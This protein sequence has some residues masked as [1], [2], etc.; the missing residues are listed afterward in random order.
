MV[1]RPLY[2]WGPLGCSRPAVQTGSQRGSV[3]LAGLNFNFNRLHVSPQLRVHGEA[4]ER[5]GR[6]P[7][8]R[9]RLLQHGIR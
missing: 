5:A 2:L 3:L 4:E 6:R 1:H 9:T 7:R 8:Q